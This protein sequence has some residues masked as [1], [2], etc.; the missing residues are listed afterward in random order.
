MFALFFLLLLIYLIYVYAISPQSVPLDYL[1]SYLNIKNGSTMDFTINVRGITGED[2]N[3]SGSYDGNTYN[4]TS[5]GELEKCNNFNTGKDGALN[6][7]SSGSK[8]SSE[9]LRSYYQDYDD[10]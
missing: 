9:R 8:D 10:E 4:I 5:N 7:I 3:I 2:C 6:T 1:V